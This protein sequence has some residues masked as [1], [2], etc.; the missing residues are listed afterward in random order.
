MA[1]PA[2]IMDGLASA[3]PILAEFARRLRDGV[4]SVDIER[5]TDRQT[6]A[7]N[8][9]I[10]TLPTET[11]GRASSA[12]KARRAP[13][14]APAEDERS[15][16]VG[17]RGPLLERWCGERWVSRCINVD[18]SDLSMNQVQ[19]IVDSLLPDVPIQRQKKL[20]EGG[21]ELLVVDRDAFALQLARE[22]VR[23]GLPRS[24]IR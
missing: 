15:L 13:V 12:R 14:A 2:A 20:P 24:S 22:W 5:E 19:Q 16:A 3:F 11:A 23:S 7:W 21:F 9:L 8:A 4:A 18:S 10:G 17:V 6:D 1:S